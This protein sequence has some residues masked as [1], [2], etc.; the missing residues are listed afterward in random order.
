MPWRV[1]TSS[2]GSFRRRGVRVDPNNDRIADI[3]IYLVGQL[4][5]LKI[6]H[7]VP[8]LIFEFVS[9]SKADRHRDYILKRA[10]Y[11]RVGVREYV[12]VDRFDR[13]VTVL[14]LQDG[15]YVERVIP[16]DG[17]YESPLLPDLVIELIRIW[18]A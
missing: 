2:G 10:E 16:V 13:K 3:G 7:L 17:V 8:D 9:P 11:Q 4:D 5:D 12:I 14:T 18:P 1:P 6:P 15:V